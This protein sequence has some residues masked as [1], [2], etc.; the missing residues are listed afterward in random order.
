MTTQLCVSVF[1]G[2]DTVAF[3]II[4]VVVSIFTSIIIPGYSVN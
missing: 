3:V 4:S 2:N 1:F